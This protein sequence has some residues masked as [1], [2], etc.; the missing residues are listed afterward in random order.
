MNIKQAVDLQALKNGNTTPISEKRLTRIQVARR[1][2][3]LAAA[4]GHPY[5]NISAEDWAKKWLPSEEFVLMSIE[6]TRAARPCMPKNENLVL[7]NISAASNEEP[8][9]VDTN[10][11]RVGR[12][13]IGYVPE[14][15]V[16]D[17]KHRHMA[18]QMKGDVHITAWVGVKALAK[19]EPKSHKMAAA[20]K[21]MIKQSKIEVA[22]AMSQVLRQDTEVKNSANHMPMPGVKGNKVYAGP[23]IIKK[24]DVEEAQAGADFQEPSDENND[25]SDQ[26]PGAGGGKRLAPSKGASR[27]ELSQRM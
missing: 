20:A 24:M 2:F 26:A 23:G 25:P 15:I 6:T 8:I 17:G 13:P 11:Q 4:A 18:A 19:V 9:V 16:I 12:S 1:V 3:K 14:V 27:S 10:K 22:A 21:K 5:K 7:K